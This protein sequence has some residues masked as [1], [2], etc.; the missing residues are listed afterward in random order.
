[1]AVDQ[2]W[3]DQVDEAVIEPDLPICDPH[4]HLWDTA[5][6]RYLLADVLADTGAG[7]NVR[8]TVFV[9]C[10]A[11][12][13]S[14]GP[15]SLRPVGETEF[16][17]SVAEAS[18]GASSASGGVDIAAGIISYADLLLGEAAGEVLD[19][20]RDASPTRFRGIRHAC[21]WDTSEDV[22][23]SHTRPPRQLYLDETFRRGFECLAQRELVFDAW[24]YHTQLSELASLARAFA[25]TTIVLDHVGG[26]LGIGPYAGKRAEVYDIWQIGI[27]ELAACP[28]VVVKLGG[29][30][31]PINGFDWHKREQPPGSDELAAALAP[32]VMF[33][34][35]E[36]GPERCMFESNFP[37]DKQ[38]CSYRVLW[39]AFKRLAADFSTAEKAALF[40]DT[41]V[42]VY[43][44]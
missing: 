26:P 28:N 5:Q 36:F 40:H 38:S 11:E 20:H 39:N 30:A 16:V 23:N 24:L 25:D 8:S 9:E 29:L 3:L 2:E 32:Y 19:A 41:A 35:D 18:A 1:V 44:L 6:S 21:G 43:G 7:H 34:I 27:R 13:R 22:R 33:C 4:H 17:E 31:M 14:E 37:V 42:R 12:Y 10:M 15:E